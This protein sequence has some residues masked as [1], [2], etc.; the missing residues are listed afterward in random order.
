M[1]GFSVTPRLLAAVT[2]MVAVPTVASRMRRGNN[3]GEED[4]GENREQNTLHG[5]ISPGG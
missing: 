4:E 1:K 3:A 2:V 5:G